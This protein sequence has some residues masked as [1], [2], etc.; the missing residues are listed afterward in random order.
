L[1]IARC[2]DAKHISKSKCAKQSKHTIL[3]ALLEVAMSK[4]CTP[5]WREAHFE[6]EPLLE[7]EM[8]K[9]CTPL[10]REA[11]FE[12][13]MLKTPHAQTTFEGSDAVSRGR[14][15]GFCTLPKVSKT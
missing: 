7:V 14:R 10:W 13:K 12:V 9:K 1:K 8:S 3:G 15:K 5:S 11:H 4:K 6:V 2:C